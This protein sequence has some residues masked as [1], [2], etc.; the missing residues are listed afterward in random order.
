ML[1]SIAIWSIK[2]HR[3]PQ[4]CV[5]PKAA[6]GDLAASL[7]GLSHGLVIEGNAVDLL[8]NGAFF[9]ALLEEIRAAQ[10]SV[11]FETDLWKDGTL[12]RRL[13]QALAERARAGLPVRVLVDANG[14]KEMGEA[15]PRA[16]RE[17]GCQFALYHPKGVRNLGM[18]LER[19]HRKIT[20]ID[21]RIAFIGGHC[22]VDSWLG[23]AQDSEHCRDISVRLRGPIVH[24][25]QSAF[26]ENWVEVTGELFVG[27]AYF[28]RLHK[29]G[30]VAVHLASMKPEGAAPAVK[31][32]HYLAICCAPLRRDQAGRLGA[33][34]PAASIAGQRLL[35]HQ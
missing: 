18:L 17:A 23:D 12:S 1:L 34:P 8:Q 4:L 33:P 15:A 19:D 21:G 25:A 3:D 32:L 5:E 22:I 13:T 6:L 20:V 27:D 14:G 26:S 31:I 16:L 24:A 35:P 28:P 30:E 7:A 11:H 10:R 29:A 2:R 9:D